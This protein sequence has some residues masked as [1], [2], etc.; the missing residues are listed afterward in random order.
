MGLLMQ[1]MNC[2]HGGWTDHELKQGLCPG[3]QE[4]DENDYDEEYYESQPQ[5]E[6]SDVIKTY[7]IERPVEGG[8]DGKEYGFTESEGAAVGQRSVGTNAEGEVLCASCKQ[9]MEED[10]G[11]WGICHNCLSDEY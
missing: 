3:C 11:R 7:K 6:G 1:C 8:L 2:G 5:A 9:P 10:T 4:E